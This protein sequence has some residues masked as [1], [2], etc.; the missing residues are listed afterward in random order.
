MH[1]G[2]VCSICLEP[3]NDSTDLYRLECGHIFHTD[4][5]LNWFRSS[6]VSGS[7]CPL[8]RCSGPI[9][10]S[11]RLFDV[12]TRATYLR[13]RANSKDMPQKLKQ[14]IYNLRK[15]EDKLKVKRKALR[16]FR[17]EHK[18]EIKQYYK[19]QS[20]VWKAKFSVRQAKSTLGTYSTPNFAIPLLMRSCCDR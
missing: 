17:S 10:G 7:P 6:N 12:H 5:I 9:N 13:R 11:L 16:I 19:L 15:K 20:S 8:C 3:I 4:C 2:D 18:E 14:L 1:R